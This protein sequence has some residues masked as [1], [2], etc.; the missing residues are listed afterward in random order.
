MAFSSTVQENASTQVCLFSSTV[1]LLPP[2]QG[3]CLGAEAAISSPPCKF[4]ALLKWL[5]HA[6]LL[7]FHFLFQAELLVMEADGTQLS[8]N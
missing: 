8:L 7:A 6:F 1:H 2:L 3:F 4:S 5:L